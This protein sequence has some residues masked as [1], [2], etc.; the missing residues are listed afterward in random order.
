MQVIYYAHGVTVYDDFAH[1]P[2]AIK[3]TLEGL[4]AKVGDSPIVAVIEPRS[5][6]MRLGIHK[7][8]L[9][10][11]V[12]DADQVFWYQN[13]RI[14]WDINAVADACDVPSTATADIESLLALTI[15]KVTDKAN[16]VIMS[17]GGF[18]GFHLRLIERLQAG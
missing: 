18:E 15:S 7:D 8:T 14:D 6:T 17:N 4:R 9:S 11:A 5:A 10:A 3:T 1:H 16:I 13:P 2:T 12:A